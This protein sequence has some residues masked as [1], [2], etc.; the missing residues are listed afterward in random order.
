MSG[1]ISSSRAA[2]MRATTRSRR[3]DAKARAMRYRVHVLAGIAMGASDAGMGHV[4]RRESRIEV[5]TA[6]DRR[7]RV[8][9]R[10]DSP[11]GRQANAA[12]TRRTCKRAQRRNGVR[13]ASARRASV[14]SGGGGRG[15]TWRGDLALALGQPGALHHR[16]G[17][18]GENVR[19][20]LITLSS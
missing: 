4:M 14:T 11:A 8:D 1:A 18:T 2:R 7:R 13:A 12:R 9:A 10:N 19:Y 16:V 5:E 20:H 17:P 6:R 15:R 3:G